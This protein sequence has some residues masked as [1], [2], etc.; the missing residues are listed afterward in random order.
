MN[1]QRL[2]TVRMH[3]MTL[4]EILIVVTL[5]GLLAGV[6]VKSLGGSLEAGRESTARMFATK[7]VKEA[8]TAY[9]AAHGRY[10]K[11]AAEIM[12]YLPDIPSTPWGEQYAIMIYNEKPVNERY[13]VLYSTDGSKVTVSN[14]KNKI[15]NVMMDTNLSEVQTK[16]VKKGKATSGLSPD[17]K[18]RPSKY[19]D[20]DGNLQ[21]NPRQGNVRTI[22]HVQVTKNTLE[23]LTSNQ[24]TNDKKKDKGPKGNGKRK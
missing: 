5:L 23:P 13:I 18:K 12:D 3:G 1:S 14:P 22:D 15:V 10:P 17:G 2:K 8:I 24:Q 19:K 20:K 11:T 9:Q 6:L 16:T 4:I 7:T 21:E